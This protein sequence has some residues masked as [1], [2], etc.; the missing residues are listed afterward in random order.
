MKYR[1][2]YHAGNFADVHKHVTLVAL[3]DAL[4]RKDAGFLY[5]D[6]HAGRGSY[7]LE[8]GRDTSQAEWRD[9]VGKLLGTTPRAAELTRWLALAGAEAGTYPGSPLLA[10]ML[11]RPA[12]RAALFELQSDECAALHDSLT[13][14]ARIRVACGDGYHALKALLPPAERRGLIFIDPPY[15]EPADFDR[16]IDALA[17]GLQRFAT[18]VFCVWAPVKHATDLTRW[19][20]KLARRAAR[21]ILLSQLWRAPRDARAGLAG[22]ALVIVN[23]PWQIEARM[24]EWLPELQQLMANHSGA[25]YEVRSIPPPA[26]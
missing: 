6:T 1:H 23:P 3:L 11:L 18:G 17:N 9:G 25:G 19:V 26:P 4:L 2:S 5:L 13:S 20:G 12:D 24:R 10:A 14:A 21:P 16:V 7:P 22:S 8:A 15:E